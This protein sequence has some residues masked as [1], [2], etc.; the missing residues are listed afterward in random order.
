MR[1]GQSLIELMYII[2]LFTIFLVA[3]TGLANTYFVNLRL[4][5]INREVANLAFRNC[6]GFNDPDRMRACLEPI[7]NDIT[8]KASFVLQDFSKPP[9]H[10]GGLYSHHY[11]DIVLTAYRPSDEALASGGKIGSGL[12]KPAQRIVT[13]KSIDST[14]EPK[15]LDPATGK[16]NLTQFEPLH[17]SFVYQKNGFLFL[18]ESYYDYRSYAQGKNNASFIE[19]LLHN[20]QEVF[21]NVFGENLAMKV[22]PDELY[23][24]VFF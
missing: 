18:A 5:N 13:V 12:F 19:T 14:H 21:G 17:N 23:T 6:Q 11:G 3:S 4:D 7:V 16:L 10:E 24:A 1:K 15:Y 20:I 9:Q 22:M 2:P 8:K